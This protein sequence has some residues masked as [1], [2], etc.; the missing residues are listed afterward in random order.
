GLSGICAKLSSSRCDARDLAEIQL[1]SNRRISPRLPQ[2]ARQQPG[3]RR[4]WKEH[5]GWE[6]SWLGGPIA[7]ARRWPPYLECPLEDY[8]VVGCGQSEHE[9]PR[10]LGR[11]ANRMERAQ[12]FHQY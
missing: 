7:M 6:R 1:C 3:S 2:P 5:V 12:E 9:V 10:R 4:F 8:F 11:I